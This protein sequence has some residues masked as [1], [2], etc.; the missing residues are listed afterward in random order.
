MT[1]DGIAA[2]VQALF[3]R[4]AV[5]S[6]ATT[7]GASEPQLYPEESSAIENAV[8]KRRAEFA[9]GRHLARAALAALGAAPVAV[10]VGPDREPLWPGGFVG[11]ITHTEGLVAAV[12]ARTTHLGAVGIDAEAATALPTETR[13]LILLPSEYS[14]DEITETLIFSAKESIYKAVF[15]LA[16][17]W[18]DFQE[19]EVSLDAD[20]GTFTAVYTGPDERVSALVDLLAGRF[21]R[22]DDFV[23]TAC[24]LGPSDVAAVNQAR[25]N[26]GPKSD[27]KHLGQ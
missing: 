8:P 25:T 2:D 1:P 26:N 24:Y 21:L 5:T 10:Q 12:V 6:V 16:R 11:S 9:H 20:P 23:V 22:N 19:V 7:H 27:E 4:G 3:G 14:A 18:I 17:L 13:P 15:P